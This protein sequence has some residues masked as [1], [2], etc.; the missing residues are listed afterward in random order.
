MLYVKIRF[1]RVRSLQKQ[2]EKHS[3]FE[4]TDGIS[5]LLYARAWLACFTS[6]FVCSISKQW[7]SQC[8]IFC[9]LVCLET[10]QSRSLLSYEI[11]GIYV[12]NYQPFSIQTDQLTHLSYAFANVRESGKVYH[13]LLINDDM[14]YWRWIDISQIS[15]PTLINSIRKTIMIV[16]KRVISMVVLNRCFF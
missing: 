14:W 10:K 15:G 9:E 4:I 8:C 12:R 13:F 7:L 1:G 2:T 11:R 3:D 5:N 16:M 6:L